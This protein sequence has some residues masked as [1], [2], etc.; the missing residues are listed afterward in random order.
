MTEFFA[1]RSRLNQYQQDYIG[2]NED[3]AQ[4]LLSLLFICIGINI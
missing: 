2:L 1:E 4:F 3:N